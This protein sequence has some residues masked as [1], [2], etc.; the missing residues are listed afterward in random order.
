MRKRVL[1]ALAFIIACVSVKAGF[2]RED[3]AAR[4]AQTV[5][6]MASQ[7]QPDNIS[8][9]RVSG[10]GGKDEMPNY[11]IF[12]NPDG[13]W[14]IISADDRT[15]PVLAYSD[16][17]YFCST[18][19]PENLE[20]W[21]DGVGQTIE[22]I[23]KSDIKASPQVEAEWKQDRPLLAAGGDRKVLQTANWNQKEPYNM[24]CPVVKGENERSVAG[25][26]ATATAIIM[27]Y[28]KWPAH[29]KGVVGGYYT[30]NGSY[31][32]AYSIE[33]HYYDW[34]EMPLTDAAGKYSG[35]TE[36]Q[37][38]QVAQ[39]IHDCGVIEK[40][41]YSLSGSASYSIYA[42]EGLKNHLYYSQKV[43][44]LYK[45]NYDAQKW[46][47]I[48]RREIDENRPVLYGGNND[49]AGHEFVCDGYDSDGLKLHFNWGWGGKSNGFF[50][51]D[52]P[53]TSATSPFMINQ[54]A[55]V[56]ICP[57]NVQIEQTEPE[58]FS[59]VKNDDFYGI[60]PVMTDGL[61]AGSN[62]RF[63]VGNFLCP[64]AEYLSYRFKI[65]LFDKDGNLKQEG[66]NHH[67]AFTGHGIFCESFYTDPD[68]LAVIPEL[69]DTFKLYVQQPDG[70]WTNVRG[71]SE[72]NP[73]LKYVCCGVTMDPVILLPDDYGVGQ[74]VDLRLSLGFTPVK[75]VKWSVNGQN[76]DG[77]IRLQS[78]KTRIR[79]D[80]KYL[81]GSSG[82]ILRT[83]DLE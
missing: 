53:K 6:G 67:A 68:I 18:D 60:E 78:G 4:Y 64:S 58:L 38:E 10:R 49:S 62:L 55:L 32:S 17:G 74:E 7:P 59:I 46:F 9:Q 63:R 76:S 13:G 71:N 43:I 70:T 28:H 48:I 36:T 40:T 23:R 33:N 11:Y 73:D 22:S 72:F 51:V 75:S 50:S 45:S 25:C 42:K 15:S 14:V 2:V 26:V 1:S 65:C 34:D 57:E 39:L 24:L 56:G 52:L 3:V 66:W 61:T 37:L 83:V 21:M 81:D 35:W 69:T 82:Y 29:G 12:N 27:R 41:D 79:A 8:A 47:S 44:Y 31:V 54:E 5:M 80:V 16:N 77:H 20:L 30:S 19:M